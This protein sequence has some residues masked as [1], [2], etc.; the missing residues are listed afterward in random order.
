MKITNFIH[1]LFLIFTFFCFLQPSHNA[2]APLEEG[3]EDQDKDQDRGEG[4]DADGMHEDAIEAEVIDKAME[5]W[6]EDEAKVMF[7]SVTK[8]C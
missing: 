3:V 2:P 6:D 4:D 8:F 1:T 7:L 5:E